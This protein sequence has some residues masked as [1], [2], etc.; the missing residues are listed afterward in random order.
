M[1]LKW[2][3]QDEH[4]ETLPSGTQAGPELLFLVE[5]EFLKQESL[6]TVELSV[7]EEDL[8]VC[9]GCCWWWL[10][11]M[12][13]VSWSSSSIV[14]EEEE[15]EDVVVVVEVA[16]VVEV[17]DEVQ[18]SSSDSPDEMNTLFKMQRR[19]PAQFVCSWSATPK[20]RQGCWL[21]RVNTSRCNQIEFTR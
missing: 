9:W 14:V 2:L 4:W 12:T 21:T 17:V 20:R 18:V 16:V 13:R 11:P 8:P 15:E 3:W 6:E 10:E 7:S 5:E 19:S 1:R